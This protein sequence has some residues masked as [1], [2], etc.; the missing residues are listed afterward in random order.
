MLLQPDWSDMPR[1]WGM[2][3]QYCSN[4]TR[5]LKCNT[6]M[7][8][9]GNPLYFII[10]FCINSPSQGS[11]TL[12]VSHNVASSGQ[13]LFVNHA[14]DAPLAAFITVIHQPPGYQTKQHVLYEKVW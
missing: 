10:A 12:S 9:I 5:L 1:L 2:S 4:M 14:T 11:S 13:W 6:T 3:D 8:I 7:T